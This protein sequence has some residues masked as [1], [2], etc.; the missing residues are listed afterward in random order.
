MCTLLLTYGPNH[1]EDEP[2]Q[3]VVSRERRKAKAKSVERAPISRAVLEQRR[4]L[5]YLAAGTLRPCTSANC[6]TRTEEAVDQ[7]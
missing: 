3:V 2:D 1:A 5:N 6:R 4:A 7:D